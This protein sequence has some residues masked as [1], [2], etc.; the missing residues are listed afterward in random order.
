[1]KDVSPEKRIIITSHDAFNYLCADYGI[2]PYSL[3]GID[4]NS[5]P[6]AKQVAALI[7]L[8][9]SRAVKG[10]LVENITNRALMEQ[11]A[12]ETHVPVL[13]KLY[14]DALCGPG[15]GPATSYVNL[16]THNLHVIVSSWAP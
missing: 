4:T 14:S 10:L 3:F 2:S 11:I 6:S 16:L 1:M 12:E 15:E 5:Q 13:E 9:R 7:K 8:I